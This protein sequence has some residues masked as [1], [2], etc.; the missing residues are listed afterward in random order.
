MD[1]KTTEKELDNKRWKAEEQREKHSKTIS[2]FDISY[3][4]ALFFK[5]AV[6]MLGFQKS[7]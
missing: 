4:F 1:T 6:P 2:L 5:T 3:G 7:S